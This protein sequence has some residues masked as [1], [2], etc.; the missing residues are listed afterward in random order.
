MDPLNPQAQPPTP[1]DVPDPNLGMP[2]APTPPPNMPAQPLPPEQPAPPA[3]PVDTLGGD[4]MLAGAQAPIQPQAEAVAPTPLP[5][6]DPMPASPVA[7]PAAF[8]PEQ[9]AAP[10]PPVMPGNPL[11][12]AGDPMQQMQQAPQIDPTT[13]QQTMPNPA[14]GLTNLPDASTEVPGAGKRKVLGVMLVGFGVL[15]LIAIAVIVVKS[16]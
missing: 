11:Q 7:A 2:P 4:P 1:A 5:P 15:A 12:Q 8:Q 9:P 3:A 10:A 16:L 13:S 6:L 14:A